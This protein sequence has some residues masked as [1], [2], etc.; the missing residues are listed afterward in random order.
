MPG[1]PRLEETPTLG[2]CLDINLHLRLILFSLFFLLRNDKHVIF[3]TTN[4]G[5]VFMGVDF[6]S[7]EYIFERSS[8]ELFPGLE[9]KINPLNLASKVSRKI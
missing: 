4:F 6:D 9:A 8:L 7:T 2:R 3:R 5:F 1:Y